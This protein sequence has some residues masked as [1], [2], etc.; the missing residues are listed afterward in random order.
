[1]AQSSAGRSA[2]VTRT[3]DGLRRSRPYNPEHKHSSS[4]IPISVSRSRSGFASFAASIWSRS[5]PMV[6][7]SV[8]AA[9]GGRTQKPLLPTQHLVHRVPRHLQLADDLLGEHEDPRLGP[10]RCR[11]EPVQEKTNV[12]VD[13]LTGF[14]ARNRG[15]PSRFRNGPAAGSKPV[16]CLPALGCNDRENDPDDCDPR[17]SLYAPSCN[18]CGSGPPKPVQCIWAPLS[19]DCDPGRR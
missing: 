2:T 18:D 12:T 19:D 8:T 17:C 1:M 15:L 10:C 5:P 7:A 6:P 3:L 13:T 9:P 4:E 11:K 14:Y 16:V